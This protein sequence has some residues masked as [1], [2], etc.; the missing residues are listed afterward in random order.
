MLGTTTVRFSVVTLLSVC[1]ALRTA[2]DERAPSQ[3][4]TPLKRTRREIRMLDH[5]YKGGIVTIT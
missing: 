4:D 3:V 5:I 2:A 1:G